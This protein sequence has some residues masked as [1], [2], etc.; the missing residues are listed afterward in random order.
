MP[1]PWRCTLGW[2][3]KILRVFPI[4]EQAKAAGGA[5]KHAA[6]QEIHI[7]QLKQTVDPMQLRVTNSMHPK[8][9]IVKARTGKETITV[10][11]AGL[12]SSP[13]AVVCSTTTGSTLATR[14]RKFVAG[15]HR[16]MVQEKA[17]AKAMHV[18]HAKDYFVFFVLLRNS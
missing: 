17:K 7:W 6:Q 2:H 18:L 12:L 4:A 13:F 8:L 5:H 3:L 16:L 9:S 15:F 14:K 1:W 10:V 11:V